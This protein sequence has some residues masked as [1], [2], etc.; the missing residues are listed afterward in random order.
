MSGCRAA[1]EAADTLVEKEDYPVVNRWIPL[2]LG[3]AALAVL[4]ITAVPGAAGTEPGVA[5]GVL[6][7]S[8]LVAEDITDDELDA[9]EST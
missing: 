5:A 7:V 6:V 2:A 1:P 9:I 8:L 3:A 4:G